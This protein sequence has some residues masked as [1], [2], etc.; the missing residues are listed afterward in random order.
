MGPGPLHLSLCLSLYLSR[1]PSFSL[2][3]FSHFT[4]A[5]EAFEKCALWD[6]KRERLQ[7]SSVNALCRGQLR[8]YNTRD[9]GLRRLRDSNFHMCATLLFNLLDC[10]DHTPKLVIIK[11]QFKHLILDDAEEVILRIFDLMACDERSMIFCIVFFFF[12]L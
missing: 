3:D 12:F 2:P 11:L 1:Y 7:K 4:R 9:M 10:I 5:S 6:L 8:Q